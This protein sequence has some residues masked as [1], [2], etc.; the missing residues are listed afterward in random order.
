M[1]VSSLMESYFKGSPRFDR[2][3]VGHIKE[4]VPIK[5]PNEKSWDLLEEPE[6]LQ[7]LF[8]FEKAPNMVYFLEDVIQLQEQM[9]HHGKLLIDGLQILVQI[10]TKD[11]NRVTDLDVEWTKKVDEIYK[12]VRTNQ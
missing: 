1:N 4:S 11:M 5:V 10:S 2:N 3:L 12:D 6:V 7:R 8:R 9:S